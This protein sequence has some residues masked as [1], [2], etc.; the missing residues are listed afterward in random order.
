MSEKDIV[1]SDPLRHTSAKDNEDMLSLVSLQGAVKLAQPSGQ[2]VVEAGI[3]A[4][5]GLKGSKR[6]GI[7]LLG[8]LAVENLNRGGNA[9]GSSECRFNPRLKNHMV[10]NLLA[11]VS[12]K[13]LSFRVLGDR[14]DKLDHVGR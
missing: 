13:L 1:I 3:Y 8:N 7:K 6:T 10:D 9:E 14:S 5:D 2:V 11:S 4:K 12:K